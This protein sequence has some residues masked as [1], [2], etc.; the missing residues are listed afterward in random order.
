MRTY[1]IKRTQNN[2]NSI[3]DIANELSV[4]YSPWEAFKN[5]YKTQAYLLYDNSNIYVSMITNEKKIRIAHAKRD[6]EVYK[7]S[8]MEFFIQ[9]DTD[10][11][12]Y[13][14]FEINATGALLLGYGKD[15]INRKFLENEKTEQF[16]IKTKVDSLGWTLSF[17]IPFEFLKRHFDE[18]SDTMRGNFFKCGD[19]TVVTHYGVWNEIKDKD[20]DFHKSQYFGELM[21]EKITNLDIN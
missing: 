1:L 13:L 11:P 8:C 6:S 17:R 16:R 5:P 9:P 19:E 20:V 7:D 10:D 3:T 14:N 2:D 18:I 12:N 21:F 15:R 4:D